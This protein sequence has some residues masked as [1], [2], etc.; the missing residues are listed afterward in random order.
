M[1]W[2]ME[3][4]SPILPSMLKP[5]DIVVLLKLAGSAR[6]WTFEQLAGQL[7]MSVSALHRSLGRAGAAGLYDA[8]GRRVVSPSLLEFIVHAAKYLFPAAM[9][10][11]ARGIPTAW[12]APP[13]SGL[14]ASS[15]SASPVWPDARGEVRGLALEPLHSIAPAA[16]KKDPDL[17]EKLALVD[18]IRLGDARQRGIAVEELTK[19]L[20]AEVVAH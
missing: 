2:K 19:R 14:I 4:I 1:F 8:A 18:A 12:A 3:W 11:E 17:A 5:Q 7:S 6:G 10:G 13:L 16:A 20:S 15:G 9:K